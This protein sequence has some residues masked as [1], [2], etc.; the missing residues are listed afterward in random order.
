MQRIVL[1]A[2][3]FAVLASAASSEGISYTRLSYD[4][5]A[6]TGEFGDPTLGFFQGAI[7]Y[8]RDQY[9]FGAIFDNTSVS[10]DVGDGSFS[11]LGIWGG[12]VVTPEILAG[13]GL[14]NRSGDTD[15]STS[16]E[17]FGQYVTS[18]YG[19]AINYTLLED[20][21]SQT[22][23]FGRYGL[24]DGF[25]VGGLF[26]SNSASEGS[27][28]QLH[29]NFDAGAVD[30]RAFV[31]G[32]T[33]ID[34]NVF[35]LRG[36]YTFGEEFR[37]GG[38]FETFV[39]AEFNDRTIQISGGYSFLDDLWIDGSVGQIDLDE[40]ATVDFVRVLLTYETG[41]RARLDATIAQDSSDD[42]WSGVS[43]L[44]IFDLGV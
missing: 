24:S 11:D 6:H 26:V 32:N 3:A 29:A 1:T 15:E 21:E 10:S 33:E 38:A 18:A 42:F 36:N 40:G 2:A 8:E 4:Y 39:G 19:A 22:A 37:A 34:G 12:Y 41:D 35:G 30:A 23:L 7:D 28:Y 27:V 5:Q 20:D 16:Y 14:I 31:T 43:P 17:L 13:A 9:V 25:E 44:F